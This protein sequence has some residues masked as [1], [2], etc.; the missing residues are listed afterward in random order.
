MKATTSMDY[1]LWLLAT[2][3]GTITLTGWVETT[4][5]TTENW[6]TYRIC[7]DRQ[8]LPAR[9][10]ELGLTLA[11][12]AHLDDLDHDWDVY[13]EHRD[14]KALRAQLDNDRTPETA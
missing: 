7:S 1:G 2:N 9:L 14:L 3:D 6:P 11:A 8:Q 13:V 10:D 5:A 12:G 4:P